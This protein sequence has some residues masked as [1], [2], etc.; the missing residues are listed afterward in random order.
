MGVLE[1][2]SNYTIKVDEKKFVLLQLCILFVNVVTQPF[3][4]TSG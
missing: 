1:I 4:E 2:D 3:I